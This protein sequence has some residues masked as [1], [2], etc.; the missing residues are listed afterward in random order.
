ML[1]IE[2]NKNNNLTSHGV[3]SIIEIIYRYERITF[4]IRISPC[5]ACTV[6]S[7]SGTSSTVAPHST[8]WP[9][10]GS[11]GSRSYAHSVSE[12]HSHGAPGQGSTGPFS[13]GSWNHGCLL[14]GCLTGR[15]QGWSVFHGMVLLIWS[16]SFG[17]RSSRICGKGD[18]QGNRIHQF[19]WD[20]WQ[21][22]SLSKF[23]WH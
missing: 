14:S 12:F 3:F 7:T 23:Q 19:Q 2:T 16:A 20:Q 13:T 22:D 21:C 17:I 18:R 11:W 1:N 8:D 9:G 4:I 6:Y 10:S 15:R 5:L